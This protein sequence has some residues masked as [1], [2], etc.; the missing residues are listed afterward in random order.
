MAIGAATGAFV[1]LLLV[2]NS[3]LDSLGYAA[4]SGLVALGF[5]VSQ[6]PNRR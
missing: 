1:V 2:G 4:L 3:F 6:N 5:A